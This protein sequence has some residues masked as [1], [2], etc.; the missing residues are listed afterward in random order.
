MEELLPEATNE[1]NGLYPSGYINTV[2]YQTL[3]ANKTYLLGSYSTPSSSTGAYISFRVVGAKSGDSMIANITL[4]RVG[5]TSVKVGKILSEPLIYNSFFSLH[6]KIEG[7]MVNFYIT[8]KFNIYIF[9][10]IP[11]ALAKAGTHYKNLSITEATLPED[12]LEINLE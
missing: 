12:A 10:D 9:D 3:S 6:Y 5:T 1:N 11:F 2:K 7:D 8:T 4:G